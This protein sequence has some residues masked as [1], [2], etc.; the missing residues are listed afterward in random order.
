MIVVWRND[1][2]DTI[3]G[4]VSQ[5]EGQWSDFFILS[6]PYNT[7]SPPKIASKGVGKAIVVWSRREDGNQTIQASTILNA[8]TL[9]E[10]WPS[11]VRLSLP[12]QNAINPQVAVDPQGNA[13]IVWEKSD[14]LNTIIQASTQS[15]ANS[16][17]WSAPIDLGLTTKR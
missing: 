16:D 7:I 11:P 10:E 2:T 13:T 8:A 17:N 4:V 9:N 6:E 1:D 3:R 15:G 5:A 12:G 14:G